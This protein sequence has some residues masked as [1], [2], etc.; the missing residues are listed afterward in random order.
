MMVAFFR[1]SSI[2]STHLFWSRSPTQS[3][4]KLL[5]P[6]ITLYS[7]QFYVLKNFRSVLRWTSGPIYSAEIDGYH[8]GFRGR[9][10]DN[11]QLLGSLTN[12]RTRIPL[13]STGPDDVVDHP[14]GP[15]SE[16]S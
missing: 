9:F 15:R 6:R 8:D 3:Y 14:G 12:C 2:T 16:T 4:R 11:L 13:R 1:K 7:L 5:I 10:P